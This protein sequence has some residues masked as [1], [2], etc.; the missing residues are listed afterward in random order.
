VSVA[1]EIGLAPRLHLVPSGRILSHSPWWSFCPLGGRWLEAAADHRFLLFC[2]DFPRIHEAWIAPHR[3]DSQASQPPASLPGRGEVCTILHQIFRFRCG[4]LIRKARNIG[5]SI[6]C[7]RFTLRTPSADWCQMFLPEMNPEQVP[8]DDPPRYNIAPT[9]AIT[10]VFREAA[11]QPRTWMK[12]RWGLVPSW[13]KDITMGNRMFNARAETV[14]EKPSFRNAYKRRRCLIPATGFYE[15]RQE[16]GHKQ[17]YCCHINHR[18][19]SFAGIWELW[20]DADGNELQ[21]CSVITTQSR[22]EMQQLHQRMPV[23]VA[24]QDYTNWLDCASEETGEADRLLADTAP[25]YQFYA[26]GRAVGNSRNEGEDLIKP[27]QPATDLFSGE[28]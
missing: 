6:L 1:V 18:L 3:G 24:P 23:Y 16:E 2:R 19:F 26:V 9:Q 13:S 22:G 28:N 10:C 12:A 27:M 17:P 8:A 7:G 21:S 15:W 25:D 4:E 5:D 14:A 20:Q 11:G